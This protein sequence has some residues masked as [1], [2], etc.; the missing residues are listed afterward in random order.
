MQT[1]LPDQEG[2]SEGTANELEMFSTRELAYYI[3]LI[4]WDLFCSIH[5]VIHLTFLLPSSSVSRLRMLVAKS[6]ILHSCFSFLVFFLPRLFIDRRLVR[7]DISRGGR[8][9]ESQNQVQLGSVPAPLQRDP[10]L[11][12]HRDLPGQHSRQTCPTFAQV[13]QVGRLVSHTQ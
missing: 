4:D 2:P 3:T 11:G 1:V 7:A 13:H 12:G 5:E 6:N 10:V 8:P 9:A